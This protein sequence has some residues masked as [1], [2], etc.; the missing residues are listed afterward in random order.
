MISLKKGIFSAVCAASVGILLFSDPCLFPGE[1]SDNIVAC[2]QTMA[3][4]A[5]VITKLDNTYKGVQITWKASSNVDGYYIYRRRKTTQ[6]WENIA[7]VSSSV[8]T[9]IDKDATKEGGLYTYMIR[10]YKGDSLSSESVTKTITRFN[11]TRAKVK[12]TY[13]Q[14][15]ARNMLKLIND[16]RTGS[17]AWAWNSGNTQKVYVSGLQKLVYDYNLEKIA[18]LRAAEIAVK[19]A[20]ERP[21]GKECFSVLSEYG[22]NYKTAG[23]NIAYSY[24][25]AKGAFNALLETNNYY[26]NQ[27]HRRVMLSTDYNVCAIGHA[28]VKGVDYWVQLFAYTQDDSDYTKTKNGSAGVTLE[29]ASEDIS[30]YKKNLK[31]LEATYKDYEPSKISILTAES[32]KRYV[33]LTYEKSM[34]A[35]GYEIYRSTSKKSG[36]KRV[37]RVASQTKLIFTD[38]KLSRNKKYYYYI[39]PYRIVHDD[40]VYGKKSKV[41]M[42]KTQ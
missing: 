5:P 36:Y 9:Y 16:F 29:I 32:G 3:V 7:S 4:A 23:E 22:Y 42:I 33:T 12:V 25:T 1:I 11:I 2:A 15:T 21:N 24:K 13:K 37:K 26:A 6:A 31:K 38:K 30:A 34:A 28:R 10:A 14:K 19:F 35:Q 39:Q 20:H 27:T 17:E 8:L 41:V 18:M 40:Y